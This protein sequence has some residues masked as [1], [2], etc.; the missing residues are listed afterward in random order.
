MVDFS[1]ISLLEK[2]DVIHTIIDHGDKQIRRRIHVSN[3][4]YEASGKHL[5]RII[6]KGGIK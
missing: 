1:G 5:E 6:H 3:G 2:Y 4:P